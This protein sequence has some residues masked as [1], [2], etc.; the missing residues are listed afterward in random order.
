MFTA[1]PHFSF[2]DCSSCKP[3]LL[4]QRLCER[5]TFAVNGTM[6]L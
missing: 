2:T 1:F 5:K 4:C 6:Y 3:V